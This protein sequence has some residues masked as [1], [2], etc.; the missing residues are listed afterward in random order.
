MTSQLNFFCEE[1]TFSDLPLFTVFV[2]ISIWKKKILKKTKECFPCVLCWLSIISKKCHKVEKPNAKRRLL[3]IFGQRNPTKKFHTWNKSFI[4]YG[5]KNQIREQAIVKKVRS[6]KMKLWLASQ[7]VKLTKHVLP[8]SNGF[9]GNFYSNILCHKKPTNEIFVK[10]IWS[11]Q[12]C[13]FSTFFSP[14]NIAP[15]YFLAS[16][17]LDLE[18]FP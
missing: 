6:V 2:D 5:E 4:L 17:D 14:N 12:L 3:N 7:V 11:K 18:L 10:K 15:R 8:T 16:K 1:E 9:F 13:W